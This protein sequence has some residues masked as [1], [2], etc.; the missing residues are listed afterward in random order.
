ME[1]I[2]DNIQQILTAGTGAPPSLSH[3]ISKG[4][5][6]IKQPEFAL[7]LFCGAR[8]KEDTALE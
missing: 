5:G 2:G 7:G 8:V 1:V 4:G 6:F 3:Q